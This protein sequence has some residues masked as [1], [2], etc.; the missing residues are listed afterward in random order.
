MRVISSQNLLFKPFFKEQF[1]RLA[2]LLIFSIFSQ[3]LSAKDSSKVD[4]IKPTIVQ[5]KWMDLKFDKFIAI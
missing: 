5:Q 2:I 3:L 1:T 4:S